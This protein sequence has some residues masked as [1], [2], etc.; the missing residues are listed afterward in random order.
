MGFAGNRGGRGYDVMD[1]AWELRLW[2]VMGERLSKGEAIDPGVGAGEYA[3][4]EA[5]V[6][7][8]VASLEKRVEKSGKM[9]K[10]LHCLAKRPIS[11]RLCAT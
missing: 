6:E 8:L 4:M 10:F 7:H 2:R 9:P 1:A 3:A 5:Q 11:K